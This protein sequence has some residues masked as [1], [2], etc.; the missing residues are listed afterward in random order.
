MDSRGEWHHYATDGGEYPAV[1][2][3]ASRAEMEAATNLVTGVTP[4]RQH[5]HPAHP[6]FWCHAATSTGTPFVLDSYNLTSLT[7]TAT[8]RLTF[9]VNVDFG[10]ANY[11]IQASVQRSSTSLTVTN[12]KYQNVRNG[13]QAVGSFEVEVYDGT[14]TTHVQEDPNDIYA[15]AQGDAV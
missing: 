3:I 9:N 14:A 4:G 15:A 2:T 1:P 13:T 8:G 6:K 5:Y 7:D 11:C 10:N 12:L